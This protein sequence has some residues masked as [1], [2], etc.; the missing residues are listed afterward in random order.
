MQENGSEAVNV[1]VCVD[2]RYP[3]RPRARLPVR[4][5]SRARIDV[6]TATRAMSARL[7]R[8]RD[9]GFSFVGAVLHPRRVH[10]SRNRWNLRLP[11]DLHRATA[12]SIAVK[13]R[14]G[15]AEFWAGLRAACSSG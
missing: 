5:R 1:D 8:V 3:L 14:R 9:R 2:V 6:H 13:Y 11:R 10:G 15:E 4:P 7:V 12:L